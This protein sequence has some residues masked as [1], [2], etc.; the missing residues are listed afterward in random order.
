[1]WGWGGE[2]HKDS[3]SASSAFMPPSWGF[4]ATHCPEF[5]LGGAEW[6]WGQQVLSPGAASRVSE[7][8]GEKKD[9][10]T[11]LLSVRKCGKSLGEGV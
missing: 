3:G 7:K 8:S 4:G 11:S 6:A 10:L 5:S 1:M 2:V 9:S